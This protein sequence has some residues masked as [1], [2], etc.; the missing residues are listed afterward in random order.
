ME[1]Q[2]GQCVWGCVG[3]LW[4]MAAIVGLAGSCGLLSAQ[5][6]E[7]E[8]LSS[9]GEAVRQTLGQGGEP[10]LMTWTIGEPMGETYAGS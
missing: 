7:R 5:T 3:R 2:H 8:V 10:C 4:L 1:K 9:G 6:I